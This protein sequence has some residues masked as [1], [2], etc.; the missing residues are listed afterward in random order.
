MKD[1]NAWDWQT[2]NKEIPVKE[3][4]DRFN[5]IE[6]L[7]VSPDGEK[8][9]SIVNTDEAEFNVCVNGEIWEETLE[10]AWGL[11]F[12]PDGRLAAMVS[13]DEEWTICV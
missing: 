4:K 11:R 5:W 1:K 12:L 6:D 2:T 7:H 9:A 8:I 3:W 10:K 13:N